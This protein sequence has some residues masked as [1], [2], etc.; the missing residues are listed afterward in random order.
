MTPLTLASASPR[1]RELLGRIVKGFEVAPSGAEE[2]SSATHWSSA[3]ISNAA[4]KA[5]DVAAKRPESLVIGADT[6]IELDGAI[7][8]KPKDIDDARRMLLLMSGRIH[9]VATGVCLR[10]VADGTFCRFVELSLVRFKRL[11]RHAIDLYLS[12]VHVLDKAGAYAIQEHGGMIVDSVEGDM[13]NVVGLPVKR[14]FLALRA[15]G[16]HPGAN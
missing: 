1:R 14:L 3:A 4:A 10:R 12:K 15:C 9:T 16:V 8:G 5:C 6:V 13:D 11:E 7:L 2:D